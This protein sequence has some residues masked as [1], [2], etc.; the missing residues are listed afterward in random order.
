M[1]TRRIQE[2][3]GKDLQ[4]VA[5]SATIV[6]GGSRQD[7]KE[8]V[9]DLASGFFG[10]D[11][12]AAN[13][14][15]ETLRRVAAESVPQDAASLRAAVEADLPTSDPESVRRHPLTAWVEEAFGLSTEEGRLIR[16]SPVTFDAAV[17]RLSE[18]SGLSWEQCSERLRGVLDAGNQAK[19]DGGQPVLA[20]RLHQW[21]S[22]GSSVYATL[23]EASNREFSMQAQYKADE[24]RVLFPLAFCRE[25]GQEYYLVSRI[26]EHGNEQLIP[27]SPIVGA[28]EEDIEGT[29]GFFAPEDG[30]LWNGDDDELPDVWFNERRSGR[31]IKSNYAPFRPARYR[32][33]PDGSISA[34]DGDGLEG[35]FQ[36]PPLPHLPAMSGGVRHATRGLS[37]T[38]FTKPDGEVDSN[39]HRS[40]R[41]G[42]WNGRTGT[43]SQ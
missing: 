25:C 2:R 40:K 8:A 32:A 22:S 26:E 41:C 29:G 10:L 6:T 20:F 27:R 18:E 13:V 33:A 30:D 36:P 24:D 23:E 15:D 16:H 35:W 5:T 7:R 28:P 4:A 39:D 37:Q 19:T 43:A 21:L 17:G 9:A 34:P 11:I 42:V 31:V 38:L 12:P 1:L 14:V 3:A